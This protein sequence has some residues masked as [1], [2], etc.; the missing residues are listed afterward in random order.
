MLNREDA[1]VLI[2]YS[3]QNS[4]K[5]APPKVSF[6]TKKKKLSEIRSKIGQL[7]GMKRSKNISKDEYPRIG[8]KRVA[9]HWK[10]TQNS[11]KFTTREQ[12]NMRRIAKMKQKEERILLDQKKRELKIKERQEKQNKKSRIS[13]EAHSKIRSNAGR[14]GGLKRVNNLTREERSTIASLGGLKIKLKTDETK[15]ES[16]LAPRNTASNE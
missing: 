6:N 7:G 5:H 16:N 10:S 13:E 4:G 12:R 14:L 15:N 1:K 11:N 3:S 8:A 2:K 9:H